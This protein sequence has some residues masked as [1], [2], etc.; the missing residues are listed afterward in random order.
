MNNIRT[1]EEIINDINKDTERRI[2]NA[3]HDY[4]QGKHD[5]KR[6]IYDEFY[7]NHRSDKGYAYVCGWRSQYHSMTGE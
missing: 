1:I 5:C 2:A 4:E 6:G 7:K 3:Q